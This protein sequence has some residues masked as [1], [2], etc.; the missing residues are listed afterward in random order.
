MPYQIHRTAKGWGVRNEDSGDWKSRD[1]SKAKAEAQLRLLRGV[2]HSGGK[3]KPTGKRR[4]WGIR[5]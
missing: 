4:R 5:K 1:T 2:E 3:W